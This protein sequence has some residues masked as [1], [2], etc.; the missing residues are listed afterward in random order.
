MTVNVDALAP[1][2]SEI[3]IGLA[4][5]V[6]AVSLSL[7]VKVTVPGVKPVPAAVI[8]TVAAPSTAVLSTAVIIAVAV[9][10]PTG[11]VTV[12]GTVA[13]RIFEDVKVTTC[14]AVVGPVRVTVTVDAFAPAFSEKAAGLAVTD[15]VASL[16]VTVKSVVAFANP[17]ADAV[18]VTVAFPSTVEL[19]TAAI[20]TVAVVLPAGIVTVAGT[21]V[22]DVFDEVRFTI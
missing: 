10:L 17:V 19:S 12:A 9:V 21:V 6:N 14:A 16:S 2:D 1:S 4:L 20:A 18:I 13:F 11:I 15:N 7:T 3:V 5:S 8:V 22:L